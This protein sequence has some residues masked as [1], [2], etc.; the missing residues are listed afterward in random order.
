LVKTIVLGRLQAIDESAVNET[1]GNA[2]TV[3]YP[4]TVFVLLPLPFVAVSVTVY[5]PGVIYVVEGF[6]SVD[7]LELP[8]FQLQLVGLLVLKSVN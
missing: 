2:E 4:T 7:V 1:V 8:K 5:T 6:C 3:I